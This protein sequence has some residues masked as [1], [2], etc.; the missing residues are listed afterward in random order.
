MDAFE[1]IVVCALSQSLAVPWSVADQGLEA[2]L[3]TS[4]LYQFSVIKKKKI[5]CRAIA[6][7]QCKRLTIFGLKTVS[8]SLRGMPKSGCYHSQLPRTPIM[9][10]KVTWL[11]IGVHVL[12]SGKESHVTLSGKRVTHHSHSVWKYG[13]GQTSHQVEIKSESFTLNN[14]NIDLSINFNVDSWI[15]WSLPKWMPGYLWRVLPH[16]ETLRAGG[17]VHCKVLNVEKTQLT[18]RSSLTITLTEAVD[19][20]V[21]INKCVSRFT[22]KTPTLPYF[23]PVLMLHLLAVKIGCQCWPY[24]GFQ[25]SDGIHPVLDVTLLA[26]AY[27]L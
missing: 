15:Y 27:W 25:T 19:L 18:F 21:D 10:G 4:V 23:I 6:H 20:E 26:C 7:L 1:H 5:Y 12:D 22:V 8:S 16:L 24:S 17:S 14:P 9:W 13:E 11:F 3:T 2:S